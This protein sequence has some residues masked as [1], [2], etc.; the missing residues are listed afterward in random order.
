MNT[1]QQLRLSNY[2]TEQRKELEYY[3]SRDNANETYIQRQNNNLSELCKILDMIDDNS[4]M[5]MFRYIGEAW[6]KSEKE[7]PT[8]AGITIVIRTK[9]TGV[10]SYL[11]INLYELI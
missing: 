1:A 4:D 7:N 3:A 9:P 6:K 2:I 8:L 10:T 11:P 5:G